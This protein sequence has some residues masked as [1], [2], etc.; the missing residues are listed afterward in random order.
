[1]NGV[2]RSADPFST[3]KKFQAVLDWFQFDPQWRNHMELAFKTW[4]EARQHL[5]HYKER[6]SESE[7]DK[8]KAILDQCQI[9]GAMNVLLLKLIGYSGLMRAS[10]LEGKYR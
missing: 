3:P 1:M 5:F 2:I 8:K 4:N 6:T 7:D 10:T 9:A